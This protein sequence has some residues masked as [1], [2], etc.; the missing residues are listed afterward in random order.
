MKSCLEPG[1]KEALLSFTSSI[2]RL[3]SRESDPDQV[4]TLYH[5]NIP[6]IALNRWK[7]LPPSKTSPKTSLTA[8]KKDKNKSNVSLRAPWLANFGPRVYGS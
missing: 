3:W 4:E 7:L 1:L 5:A 8:T 2:N 6:F